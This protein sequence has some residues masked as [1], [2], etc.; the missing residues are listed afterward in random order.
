MTIIAVPVANVKIHVETMNVL[1]THNVQLMF[2]LD[3]MKK[4]FL[5]QYVVKF[6]RVDNVPDWQK[7]QDV[8]SNVIQMLIA[9]VIINVVMLAVLEFVHYHINQNLNVNIQRG[10]HMYLVHLHWSRFHKKKLTWTFLREELLLLNVMLQDSLHQLLLGDVMELRYIF[11]FD[12]LYSGL[13]IL[14]I[15]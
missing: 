14:F 1:E 2:R 11:N 5:Y 4:L 8:K 12:N 9:V 10:H 13:M 6:T 3:N 15:S 7:I